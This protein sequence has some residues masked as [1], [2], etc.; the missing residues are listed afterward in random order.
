VSILAGIGHREP[1]ESAL[2]KRRAASFM[3]LR[4]MMPS[5]TDQYSIR[6]T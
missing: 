4:R 5:I 6:A 2:E 3:V 1:P